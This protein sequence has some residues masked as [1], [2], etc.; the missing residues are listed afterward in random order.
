M[1]HTV[2]VLSN[3]DVYGW[4]G[5]RKGQLGESAIAEKIAWSPLK[6]EGV[7]FCISD[8]ACGREFTVLCGDSEAGELVVLGAAG[9]KW[10]IRAG[11]PT[12]GSGT[13]SGSESVKG[14]QKIDASW[15]GIYVHQKDRSVLAWGRNDRGQ[16]PPDYLQGVKQVAVGSEHV[17]ALLED[18]SVVAFG[19]GEHGNCGPGIDAQG[20]IK[21]VC[22]PVPLPE[23]GFEAVGVGAGCATSWV[24]GS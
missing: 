15:H 17:L 4:G 20:N 2:V 19:W 16:L 10:E 1:G 8:A 6:I 12:S 3:G 22:G 23:T 14:Y 5:A 18:R 24:F 21:G 13:G 9:D 7:P 11:I